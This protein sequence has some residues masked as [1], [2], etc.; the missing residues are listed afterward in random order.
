MSEKKTYKN[1]T[2]A[3]RSL[4]KT[5]TSSLLGLKW[6]QCG[7]VWHT[8]EKKENLYFQSIRL[9]LVN[10]VRRQNETFC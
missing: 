8:R 2:T 5:S 7:L 9:V 10:G 3:G 1:K 6:I 4:R